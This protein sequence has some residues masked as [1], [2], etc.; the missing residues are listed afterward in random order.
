MILVDASGKVVHRAITASEIDREVR[1]LLKQTPVAE[2][3]PSSKPG[4]KRQKADRA[5]KPAG[6]RS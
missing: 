4:A 6:K 2:E 3:T 1:S 5:E